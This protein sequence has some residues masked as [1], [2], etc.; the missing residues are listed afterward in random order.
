MLAQGMAED[1]DAP[2]FVE[3]RP[4][5][6]TIPQAACHHVGVIG[7]GLQRVAV[8]P[9]TLILQGLRQIPMIEREKR[10]D[11]GGQQAID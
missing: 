3:S 11:I 7:E 6:D 10:L 9:T 8:G 2:G 1:G 4:Q 5:L